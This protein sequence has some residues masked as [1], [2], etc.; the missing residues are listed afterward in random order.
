MVAPELNAGLQ[1]SERLGSIIFL[2]LLATILL[3]QYMI[4]LVFW[5]ASAYCQLLLSFSSPSIPKTFSSELLSNQSLPRLYLYLGLTQPRCRT[6]HLALVELQEVY[7]SPILRPVW[8][9]L[10]G[11]SSLQ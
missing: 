6:L 2:D 7:M 3:M 5:V 8:V 4:R 1:V 10:D 11:N 9:S